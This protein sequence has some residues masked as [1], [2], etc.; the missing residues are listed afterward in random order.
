MVHAPAP[1]GLFGVASGATIINLSLTDVWVRGWLRVGGVAGLVNDGGTISNT[2]VTG[3]VEGIEDVGGLAGRAHGAT[4]EWCWANVDACGLQRWVGG[5]VGH[6]HP[7]T[8]VTDSSAHGAISGGVVVG[9][10]VGNHH[11]SRIERCHATGPVMGPNWTGGLVGYCQEDLLTD[12]ASEIPDR[13]R[14]E[15]VD[16]L[17]GIEEGRWNFKQTMSVKTKT[18]LLEEAG[19]SQSRIWCVGNGQYAVSVKRP[20]PGRLRPR[21]P[22]A[23]RWR[24]CMARSGRQIPRPLR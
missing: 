19:F 6:C 8:T 23:S 9:G 18:R 11:G 21:S 3:L 14:L 12:E 24:W 22:S 17:P 15:F 7:G 13:F 1:V 5:L 10:L 2:Q 20:C 16:Q 4:I